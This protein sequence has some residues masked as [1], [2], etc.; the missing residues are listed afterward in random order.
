MSVFQVQLNNAQ[1]GLLDIDPATGAQENPSIQRT[2]FVEG[3]N[4]TLRELVDGATF[5]DCNYWKRFEI[6]RAHV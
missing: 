6:G 5:T 3:P 1:Q 2:M 4:R